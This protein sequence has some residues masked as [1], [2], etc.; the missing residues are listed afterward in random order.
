MAH[1]FLLVMLRVLPVFATQNH[2]PGIPRMPE[3]TV[4]TLSTRRDGEPGSLKIGDKLADFTW[5]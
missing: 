4:R 2:R 5:H 3:F 1:L